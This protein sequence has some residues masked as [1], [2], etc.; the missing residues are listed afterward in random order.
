M[1]VNEFYDEIG[2]DYKAV[3]SR[4]MKDDRIYKFLLKFKEDKS[5]ELLR[6]ALAAGNEGEA[7]RAAH[8]LKGV[9]QNLA[10]DK[11]FVSSNEL[12]EALRNGIPDNVAPL[13][14]AVEADYKEI[15]EAIDRVEL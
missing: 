2:G 13:V 4:L 1:T 3:L 8:T 15:I 9:S 12:T 5:M 10:F 11:F 14:E 7:F 6:T